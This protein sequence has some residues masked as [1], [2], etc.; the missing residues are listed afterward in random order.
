MQ[1]HQI[2]CTNYMGHWVQSY[3]VQFCPVSLK[4]L[5]NSL[6]SWFL[7]LFLLL[8]LCFFPYT[9]SKLSLENFLQCRKMI[10]VILSFVVLYYSTTSEPRANLYEVLPNL[11]ES[12]PHGKSI[13]HI[14]EFKLPSFFFSWDFI[15][16][17]WNCLSFVQSILKSVPRHNPLEEKN[18]KLHSTKAG[19]CTSFYVIQFWSTNLK[20][21]HRIVQNGTVSIQ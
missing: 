8:I 6:S 2:L 3:A 9:Y 5:L 11:L 1:T 19:F 4:N 20:F 13:L 12:I 21:I 15:A 14:P 7:L 16:L 18:C 17:K 10:S